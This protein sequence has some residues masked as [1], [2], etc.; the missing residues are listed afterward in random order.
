MFYAWHST[1]LLQH[2]AANDECKAQ[3]EHQEKNHR[4]KQGADAGHTCANL[5]AVFNGVV[6]PKWKPTSKL[7]ESPER[8]SMNPMRIGLIISPKILKSSEIITDEA[9]T[10]AAAGRRPGPWRCAGSERCAS[11]SP[12]ADC[13]IADPQFANPS[14]MVVDQAPWEG[15]DQF[16]CDSI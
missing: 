5:A 8:E 10:S 14:T 3:L 9:P 2:Q 13:W 16:Q 6:I 7:Q 4:P 12:P 11:A 15:F 1:D